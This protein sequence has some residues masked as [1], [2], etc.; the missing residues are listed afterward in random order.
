MKITKKNKKIRFKYR[1]AGLAMHQGHVLIHQFEGSEYWSLPGGNVEFGETSVEALM[2]EL[3]EEAN[4]D[5]VVDRLLWVHENY[6][7]R[8]SGKQIH[9]IC[10]YYLI[11]LDEEKT[12]RFEGA[13]GDTK[14]YFRWLLLDELSSVNL[15]PSFL[16][17][18]L[19]LLPGQPQQIVTFDK[20]HEE[21]SA[22]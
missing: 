11:Q 3:K 6:F 14:L 20:K 19:H 18:N 15:V 1:V 21:D 16:K 12:I 8:P 9:E 17:A 7:E 2:R 13:E 5:V 22:D 4:L 10:L